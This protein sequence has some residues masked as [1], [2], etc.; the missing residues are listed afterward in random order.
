MIPWHCRVPFLSMYNPPSR[1]AVITVVEPQCQA[2]R[3][4]SQNHRR[5]PSSFICLLPSAGKR[6][7]PLLRGFS[8][9]RGTTVLP[10]EDRPKNE[11]QEVDPDDH[12]PLAPRDVDLPLSLLPLVA[13]LQE[14][15]GVVGNHT[16]EFLA[17]TPPHHV[18][19]VDR[20]HV[21]RPSFRFHIANKACS[22]EWHDEGLL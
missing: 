5:R 13:H 14:P 17:Y 3:H 10:P 18:L 2:R 11:H 15:L 1:C 4:A 12:H 7:R 19:L 22:K 6:Q 20:P 21:Q 9:G 8:L 16:I